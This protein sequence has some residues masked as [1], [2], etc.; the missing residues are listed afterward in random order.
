MPRM[1]LHKPT[2]EKYMYHEIMAKRPDMVE[3][4]E[5]DIAPKPTKKAV[6][7][8]AA[9]KPKVVEAKVEE[10]VEAKAEEA[11]EQLDLEALFNKE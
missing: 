6:K 2:G 8:K 3:L 4:D 11:E 5:P 7:P 1:L 9:P 10:K